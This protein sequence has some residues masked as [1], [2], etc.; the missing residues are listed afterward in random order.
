MTAISLQG[1]DLLTLGDLSAGQ[2]MGLL[3]AAA[4]LEGRQ[5]DVLKGQTLGLLFRKPSTRTRVSFEV[6]ALHLGASTIYM[7]EDQMQLS[8]GETVGDTARVLSRYLQAL[9][10]RTGAHG[11]IEELAAAASVP[12]LNALTDHYHPCQVLADLKTIREVKGTLTGIEVA[13]VGDGN[14]MLQ[15]WIQAASR[16]G[17]T[18]RAAT[19]EGFGPA[20]EVL[21]LPHVQAHPPQLLHDPL[22]AVAGADVVITDTWLSMGQQDSAGKRQA[23]AGFTVDGAMM[24]KA[25]P[26]AIFLHCLPAHRGEE[27][28]DEVL[29]GSQS[30]VFDEAENRLHV[31]KAVLWAVLA[32]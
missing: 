6:A 8:R 28:T 24:A 1:Q 18:L 22:E 4:S 3:E 30:R 11:E 29:M 16:L 27:V 7:T 19:P 31:Q 2:I 21:G 12:V 15:E 32:A 10:V 14:N 23:F 20:P 17:M 13:Y 9:V 25:R 5:A 26:D